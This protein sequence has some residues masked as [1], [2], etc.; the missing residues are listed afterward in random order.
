MFSG[1]EFM[2]LRKKGFT[3]IEM[4][5]VITIIGILI[6]L[7]LPAL[8]AAR[9]AARG[10]QCK[11]N[12]R[13]FYISMD[14]FALKD[15]GGRLSTGAYDWRRDGCPDTW[16][17]V[18]DAVNGGTCK[19]SDMLCPSNP[20][21]GSEKY[22]DLVAN[23]DTSSGKEGAPTE[24]LDDGL[25]ALL[26]GLSPAIT[27]ATSDRGAF[28]GGALLN[29]GYGTNYATSYFS[30]RTQ[31]TMVDAAGGILQVANANLKGLGGSLGPVTR[32]TLDAGANP[33]SL[34]PLMFDASVG[35]TGDSILDGTISA[36]DVTID[37]MG[38]VTVNAH[39][40]VILTA[41]SRL[42]ESFSDGPANADASGGW[43]KWTAG[44]VIN[45]PSSPDTSILLGE[46]PPPGQSQRFL[47]LQDYRDMNP[48]HGSGKGGF[49]N[50]LFADGSVKSFTDTDADGFMNPGFAVPSPVDPTVGYGNSSIELPRQEIFS[51]VF[52]QKIQIKAV[53]D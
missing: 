32:D 42:V 5:V 4:L 12:L 41:G 30:S 33:S 17:W 34:V 53:L 40:P 29:K 21:K 50:V 24:R 37:S 46:Q 22:N 35:D 15:P 27:S 8:G 25:C 28:V 52:V 20:Q 48:C 18:A 45:D 14:T 49:V 13:Q 10:A 2:K 3:L 31:P 36:G 16:G 7:L 11:S 51:G 9:E 6:A 47:A 19:P 39:G 26:A 1:D 43:S 38:T 23:A 44:T